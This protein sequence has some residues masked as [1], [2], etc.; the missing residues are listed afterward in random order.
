MDHTTGKNICWVT[1]SYADLG[2]KYASDKEITVDLITGEHYG[3]IQTRALKNQELQK[4]RTKKKAEVFTPFHVVKKMTDM[5]MDEMDEADKKYY[6]RFIASTQLEITCGEAPFLT[7]RYRMEDGVVIQP[8][9]RVGLLDR[10]LQRLH[11]EFRNKNTNMVNWLVTAR[12]AL[13]SVFGYELLGD[14]LLIAR[15]N[16]LMTIADYYTELWDDPN[17]FWD[18]PRLHSFVDIL[19]WNLWQMDGL[20]EKTPKVGDLE[21]MD[22]MIMDWQF[23]PPKSVPFKRLVREDAV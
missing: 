9:E 12:A 16:L 7:T 13:C 14:N 1:E 19:T 8:M 3:L 6:Y 23:N 5:L 11:D 21:P 20:T 17:G 4:D 18:N 22:C 15:I 2:P 10:K